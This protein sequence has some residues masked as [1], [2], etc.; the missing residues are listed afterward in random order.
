MDSQLDARVDVTLPS[1][2]RVR[3]LLPTLNTLARR[4][5]LT[6][7]LYAAVLKAE[8]D[9]E[10]LTSEP[11]AEAER[12]QKRR[13]WFSMAAAFP[14]DRWAGDA[15]EPMAVTPSEVEDAMSEDDKDAL[16]A[17]VQRVATPAQ[18]TAI[19]LYVL[20]LGPDP[21]SEEVPAETPSDW[22]RFRDVPRGDAGGEDG[23]AVGD[24]AEPGAGDTGRGDGVPRGRGAGRAAAPRGPE[25]SPVG[26]GAAR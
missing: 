5:L 9:P 23:G 19:S 6:S 14:R 18:V 8:A 1:G 3:G 22:E 15:W 13:L 26:A 12:E 24:D 17:L 7:D 16:L 10:W 21:S 2:L 20:G 25:G 11:V 4:G